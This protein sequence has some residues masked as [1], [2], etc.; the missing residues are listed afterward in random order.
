MTELDELRRR[1][2]HLQRVVDSKAT[3]KLIKQLKTQLATKDTKMA[4]LREA[5]VRLKEEFLKS[6]ENN[7]QRIVDVE[8]KALHQSRL[9]SVPEPS[10]NS[11]LECSS[12]YFYYPCFHYLI[13]FV[14]S[15]YP[16]F[17]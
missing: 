11:S 5:V 14:H 6:E 16:H 2:S 4:G 13:N 1:T 10:H 3:K 12:Y 8:E 9:P 17:S 15:Y 7:E